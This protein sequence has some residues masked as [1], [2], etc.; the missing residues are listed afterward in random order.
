MSEISDL[1]NRTVVQEVFVLRRRC[2]G[3]FAVTGV[4]VPAA[5]RPGRRT[6]RSFGDWNSDATGTPNA[7]ASRTSVWTVVFFPASTRR[8]SRASSRLRSASCS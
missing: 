5:G 4:V 7:S 1:E 8:T 6:L 3:A 2:F